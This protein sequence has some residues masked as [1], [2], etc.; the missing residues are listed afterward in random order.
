LKKVFR[1][2][3]CGKGVDT[4]KQESTEDRYL[5]VYKFI[6]EDIIKEIIDEENRIRKEL[7]EKYNKMLKT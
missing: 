2:C 6:K 1:C 7:L 5:K 3:F 4:L